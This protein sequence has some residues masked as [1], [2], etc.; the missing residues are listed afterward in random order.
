MPLSHVTKVFAASDAKIYPLTADSA[1]GTATYG[2][3]IDVPGL[4]T[5][6]ITGDINT[7]QL[8]GDNQLLDVQSTMGNITVAMEFGKLSLDLLGAWFAN[9]VADTG[10]TPNQTSVWSLLGTG[11]IGYVGLTC[12]AVAAD[13][14]AGD[15]FFD[16]TKL[17]LSS[18]PE[19]GLAE[20]DY[21][22]QSVEFRAIPRLSDGRWLS[23]GL[24]ET[25]AALA[26]PA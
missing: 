23:V 2:T 10:L 7:A 1:G 26:A 15:V 8:R 17:M 11:K 21:Q 12:K 13:A 6:T 19:L 3:G 14:I 24:R 20:E 22:A 16:L 9:T 4:R 5:V 25:A 18:F